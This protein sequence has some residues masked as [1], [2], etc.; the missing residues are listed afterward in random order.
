MSFKAD[1]QY[2]IQPATLCGKTC[3]YMGQQSC[4]TM[5]K[6]IAIWR[7]TGLKHGCSS[8]RGRAPVSRCVR[9]WRALET[10][11]SSHYFCGETKL[12]IM[13][14]IAIFAFLLNAPIWKICRKDF[15]RVK[16]G[17]LGYPQAFHIKYL[18]TLWHSHYIASCTVSVTSYII[19]I[20]TYST[21]NNFCSWYIVIKCYK[22]KQTLLSVLQHL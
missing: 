2:Q 20:L 13:E 5:H 12:M 22:N 11:C 15:C 8:A 17:F 3:K 18:N 21:L 10:A 19:I 7:V 16:W 1:A 14:H 9:C 6:T 4:L